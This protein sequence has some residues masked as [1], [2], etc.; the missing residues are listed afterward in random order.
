MNVESA[1]A[2][3]HQKETVQQR[4]ATNITTDLEENIF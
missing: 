1:G 3:V 2:E 4:L